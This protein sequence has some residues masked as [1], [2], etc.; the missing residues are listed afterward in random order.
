MV[1]PGFGLKDA[2]R[3]WHLRIDEVLR[4]LSLWPLVSDPQL[5]ARWSSKDYSLDSLEILCSKHVDDLKGASSEPVFDRLC[6]ELAKHFGDLTIQKRTFE[7]LGTLHVQ[8]DDYS[9]SCNQDHYVKQLRLISLDSLGTDDEEVVTDTDMT[10]SYSSLIGGAAW[11]LITRSDVSVHIG[12]LQRR[13]H[14]PRVQDFKSLNAVVRWMKRRPC[15]LLHIAIPAPWTLL[16]MPD[17][18]FKA[19]EPDCLATR[20]CIIMLTTSIAGSRPALPTGGPVGVVEFYSRKQPRVCRSTFSAELTSVDDACSLGLLIRG[21]FS[22]II[23][24]PMTAAD[25][26]YRTEHG[27]LAVGLDIGTDNK[28]LFSGATAVEVRVP[29]EPH[30]YYIL[31]ALRDRLDA[32]A[33]DGL[34]WID[35]RDMVC[36]AMTKGTLSRE[37]LL[38]LWRTAMLKII[39][40]SPQVWRA[41]RTTTETETDHYVQR[42]TMPIIRTTQTDDSTLRPRRPP[43]PRR[44]IESYL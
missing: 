30:L 40:E 31:K 44:R 4:E 15:T 7:H 26:A 39:G 29:S 42:P 28:G 25:L 2:P 36:D 16:V 20:A 21:M 35:T 9:V 23:Q 27:K 43:T 38:A 17:S 10:S 34:W 19:T 41:S 13:S 1:K 37:P 5:Y 32:K 12:A 11:T 24:G 18:A 22:E 3:L 33:V 8:N 6:Q 14:A